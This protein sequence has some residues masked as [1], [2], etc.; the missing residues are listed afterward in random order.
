M[1]DSP[2]IYMLRNDIAT[3]HELEVFT[4]QATEAPEVTRPNCSLMG[5]NWIDVYELGE[6][7]LLVT[8]TANGRQE[9]YGILPAINIDEATARL[10]AFTVPDYEYHCELARLYELC[11]GGVIFGADY[12]NGLRGHSKPLIDTQL[13][14]ER[15]DEGECLYS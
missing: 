12:G 10:D 2:T 4:E 9:K 14:I 7:W 8:R 3:E 5:G 15:E 6:D 1:I 11:D 13:W